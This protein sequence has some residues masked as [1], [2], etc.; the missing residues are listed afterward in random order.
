MYFGRTDAK[1]EIPI[2][3]PPHA[4]SWLIGKDS[5][6]GRDWG[7][8]EKGTTEDEMTWWHH[9]LSGHESEW[10][11]GDVDGQG[12][13]S[14]CDS[15]GHKE[16]NTTERLNWTELNYW[17]V[18]M[19]GCC[20]WAVGFCNHSWSWENDMVLDSE[21][22]FLL[23]CIKENSQCRLLPPPHYHLSLSEGLWGC[24]KFVMVVLW[25]CLCVQEFPHLQFPLLLLLFS[26]QTFYLFW[27]PLM[28]EGS[29]LWSQG[30]GI[31]IM[32]IV[33]LVP[34]WLSVTS[35]SFMKSIFKC[36]RSI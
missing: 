29:K 28:R 14:C 27:T 18:N 7:Q 11:P 13:L 10:T 1:A 31:R 20:N 24:S 16:S 23:L 6:A 12:G 4:K 9:G 21:G 8:E 15:W 35:P 30:S 2:L 25:V 34:T 17:E 32:E 5:D 22:I 33:N 3:W 36:N 26:S 19:M